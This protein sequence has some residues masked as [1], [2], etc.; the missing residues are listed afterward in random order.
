[1]TVTL[2]A[3]GCGHGGL[4]WK[5]VKSKIEETL[6][7]T[8]AKVFVFEPSSSKGIDKNDGVTYQQEKSLAGVGINSIVSDAIDYPACLSQ[9]TAKTL[10][11]LNIPI[12]HDQFDITIIARQSF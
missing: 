7:T 6:K 4:D 8:P 5:I 2:P 12:I 11:T 1:M 3:L 10:Y 9:Y